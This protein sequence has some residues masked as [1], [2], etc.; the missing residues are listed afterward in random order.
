MGVVEFL[1]VATIPPF[2]LSLRFSTSCS[3]NLRRN[4]NDTGCSLFPVLSHHSI[5][6]AAPYHEHP[7][8]YFVCV[9]KIPLYHLQFR[10]RSH[11]PLF[12]SNLASRMLYKFCNYTTL[13][14]CHPHKY[15]LLTRKTRGSHVGPAKLP[16]VSYCMCMSLHQ[17][18]SRKPCPSRPS[19]PLYDR[20]ARPSLWGPE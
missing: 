14:S 20:S 9:C 18:G 7:H 15:I 11:L 5:H 16:M 3:S 1:P 2:V 17:S 8:R 6:T 12:F 10:L 13:S 19:F 4:A